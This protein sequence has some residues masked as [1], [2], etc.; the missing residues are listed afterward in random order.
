VTWTPSASAV[1]RECPS[2][3][4]ERLIVGVDTETVGGDARTIDGDVPTS[5]GE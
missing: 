5:G 1:D 4:A 2:P 3:D